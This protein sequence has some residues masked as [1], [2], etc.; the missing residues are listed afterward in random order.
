M[1]DEKDLKRAL[2]KQQIFEEMLYA[3]GAHTDISL[4][5]RIVR[6]FQ[7]LAMLRF[8]L[9]GVSHIALLLFSSH[10][11]PQRRSLQCYDV[12]LMTPALIPQNSLFVDGAFEKNLFK[13]TE[14]AITTEA[15]KKYGSF[16]ETN[17]AFWENKNIQLL[18]P[19]KTNERALGFVGL[20]KKD[21]GEFSENDKKFLRSYLEAVKLYLSGALSHEEVLKDTVTQLYSE[22][23][24]I[25]EKNK[26]FKE[27]G[28]GCAIESHSFILCEIE[29]FENLIKQ[30]GILFRDNLMKELTHIFILFTGDP[31]LLTRYYQNKFLLVLEN[32]S[33]KETL[34]LIER[35][36]RF[37]DAYTFTSKEESLHVTSLFS[38]YRYSGKKRIFLDIINEI[39]KNL[40]R[41]RISGIHKVAFAHDFG[42]VE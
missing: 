27:V 29:N 23:H 15:L 5:A 31:N 22:A 33:F 32:L 38:F 25:K 42:E 21:E 36:K 2:K 4:N 8:P 39:Q 13:S 18:L 7:V 37:I 20:G 6:V 12:S 35:L 17:S 30:N 40:D 10:L 28:K 24:F 26:L 11:S 34:F 16:I 19:L 3:L 9:V 14:Q 1:D 41:I